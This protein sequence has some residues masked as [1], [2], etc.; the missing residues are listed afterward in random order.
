[1]SVARFLGGI[2]L[3]IKLVFCTRVRVSFIAKGLIVSNRVILS[4]DTRLTIYIP[5]ILISFRAKRSGSVG[6]NH[7]L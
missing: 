5:V 2:I 6:L 1:M 7:L 4:G 3:A